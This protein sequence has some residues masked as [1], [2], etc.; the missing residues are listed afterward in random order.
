MQ[1]LGE[2]LLSPMYMDLANTQIILV[3]TAEQIGRDWVSHLFNLGKLFDIKPGC[4]FER[5][6]LC[7]TQVDEFAHKPLKSHFLVCYSPLNLVDMSP[8]G[9]K[10]RMCWGLIS[11]VQVLKVGMLEVG[12]KAFTPQGEVLACE[13]PPD[14][15]CVLGLGFMQRLCLSLGGINISY[16]HCEFYI[17]FFKSEIEKKIQ[18]G[19]WHSGDVKSLVKSYVSTRW[20]S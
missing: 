12:Y 5:L 20:Q 18:M 4:F 15:G 16:Y 10:S 9:F 13:F 6:L 2:V 7:W 1:A 3:K 19:K 14:W 11:W 8:V 17:D